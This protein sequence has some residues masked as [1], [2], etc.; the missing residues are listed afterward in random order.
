L[1]ITVKVHYPFERPEPMQVWE[2]D[3]CDVP[4]MPASDHKRQHGIEVLAI[5]DRGTSSCV[6][7]Q[8]SQD[9]DAAEYAL[10]AIAR[11]LLVHGLPSKIACDRDP[12]W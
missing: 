5:I 8:T 10:M 9:Y 11:T 3:F 7:L 1:L 4:S 12:A 2:V 6:D